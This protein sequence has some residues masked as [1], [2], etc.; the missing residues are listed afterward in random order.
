EAGHAAGGARPG[1]GGGPRPGPLAGP[2]GTPDRQLVA[3][4]D[5]F[6][7]SGGPERIGDGLPH[8]GLD[9]HVGLA[10]G[11]LERVAQVPPVRWPPQ[12]A[13]HIAER[14]PLEVVPRVDQ[15]LID[16]DVVAALRRD[17]G[18]GRPRALHR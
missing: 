3:D 17:W 2:P 11:R 13:G 14:G 8:A 7:A 5:R 4:E 16:R 15:P 6:V 10:P 1:P 18:V 9:A 12:G